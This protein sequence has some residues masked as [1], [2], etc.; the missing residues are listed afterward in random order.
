MGPGTSLS[1][2]VQEAQSYQAS[3]DVADTCGTLGAFSQQVSAR[4]G[5]SMPLPEA[6][7]LIADAGRIQAVLAC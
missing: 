4:S 7:Q 3:G 6:Q 2:K 1:D 5:M